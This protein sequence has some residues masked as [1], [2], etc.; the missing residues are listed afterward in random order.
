[1]LSVSHRVQMIAKWTSI[2]IKIEN[3]KN[4]FG[5]PLFYAEIIVSAKLITSF[6]DGF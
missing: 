2:F 4:I 3:S 5:T 1:M 6:A